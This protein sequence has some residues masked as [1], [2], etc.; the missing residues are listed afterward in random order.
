MDCFKQMYDVIYSYM[1]PED[2][3]YQNF[4]G[5]CNLPILPI[6]YLDSECNDSDIE[7]LKPFVTTI[8]SDG[9]FIE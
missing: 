9:I 8:I 2:L 5:L 3:K 7:N 1:Y 6:P 4:G